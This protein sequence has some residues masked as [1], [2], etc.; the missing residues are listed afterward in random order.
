MGDDFRYNRAPPPITGAV[1]TAGRASGE[2]CRHA[3]IPAGQGCQAE[4]AGGAPLARA[5]IAPNG[6]AT[7]ASKAD[8]IRQI[9]VSSAKAS[10]RACAARPAAL[11]CASS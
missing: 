10:G 5:I 4:N 11:P 1:R 8:S 7:F 9:S 6:C 2:R 3:A